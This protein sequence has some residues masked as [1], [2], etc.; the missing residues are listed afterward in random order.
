MELIDRW[1]RQIKANRFLDALSVLMAGTAL[2]HVL[3]AVSTPVLTRMYTPAEIGVL[4]VFISMLLTVSVIASLLYE[5]A[6]SLPKKESDAYHLFLLA[7]FNVFLIS[8]IVLVIT[9]VVPFASLLDVPEL[10]GYMWLLSC[11]LL[12]IGIFQV[13]NA[14]A[15]R[16]E[17]YPVI[18]KAKIMMNGGTISSQIFFGFFQMG[19]AG[20][21]I[22]EVFG[23]LAGSLGYLKWLSF[24]RADKVK[25]SI[26]DMKKVAK[27][28]KSFPLVSGWSSLLNSI[29]SQL[30]TFFLAAH[31]DPLTAGLFFLAQ[32]ILT[33][34]EGLIGYS[35][36]QVYL[37]QSAQMV[38]YTK[39][40]F[41]KFC[42]D[43]IKKLLLMSL[44][45]IGGIAIFVPYMITFIFGE[46]WEGAGPFI[47][48]LSILY[49]LKIIINPLTANFYV[50]EA[51][52]YQIAGEGLRFLLICLSILIALFYMETPVEAL[53][54]ISLIGS[55]ANAVYGL[56][57]WIIIDR[58]FD[59]HKCT[60]ESEAVE[61]L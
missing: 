32:R 51:L 19:L 35:A 2:S 25:V 38:R 39:E 42:L 55:L 24:K 15:I 23:R 36:L 54:C 13:M 50:L 48:I 3:V 47:R 11:S 52:G 44:V 16:K 20:L 40:A 10:Q 57:A 56:F 22:G 59:R 21:L 26:D 34:P 49:V 61:S 14:W 6:I 53:V 37:S 12:G 31:F 7:A 41:K 30:P 1:K 8:V 28:Y 60:L 33:L 27:R 58:K 29:S 43:T 46:Q 5:S 17:A 4:S 18:S 9:L 45:V